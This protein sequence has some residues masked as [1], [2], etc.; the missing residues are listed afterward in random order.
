MSKVRAKHAS[1]FVVGCTNQHRSLFL[2]PTPEDL[3][4]QWIHFIFDGKVP[5]STPKV[6]YVCANH[7]TSDCFL[8]K[9]QYNAG[10]A[11]SLKIKHGSVP[12]VRDQTS[13]LGAA[14]TSSASA[15]LPATRN[16]ACQSDPLEMRTV[17]TQFSLRTLQ[18]HIRSTGVQ[19]TVSC[20]DF[21]VGTSVATSADPVCF[22]STP[23]KRP[24]KR[25]R[26]DL[27]EEQDDDPLEG[28]SSVAASQGLHSTY[29]LADAP[30]AL[31]ESTVLSD[32]SSPPTHKIKKYIVYENRLIEFFAVCPVLHVQHS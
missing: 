8:N 5:A 20:K 10:F 15:G 6:L 9:G 25:T 7:F 11:T 1:C 12:T 14:S 23:V 26:L 28:S 27:E 18:P 3:K 22:S 19:A 13:N 31:T 29:D 17:G 21:G 30:T 4:T 32:D 16:V 24:S 2:T